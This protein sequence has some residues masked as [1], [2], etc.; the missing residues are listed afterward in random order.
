MPEDRGAEQRDVDGPSECC[1]A[2]GR[3]AAEARL[4]IAEQQA[5]RTVP[6]IGTHDPADAER[7]P[8]MM[9]QVLNF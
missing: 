4:R 1:L 5:A 2:L 8:D 7:L 6:W 9:H 3:I